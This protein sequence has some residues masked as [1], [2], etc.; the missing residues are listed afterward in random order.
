MPG[1]CDEVDLE[2]ASSEVLREALSDALNSVQRADYNERNK[3]HVKKVSWERAR[4][5]LLQ[6]TVHLLESDSNSATID[7]CAVGYLG[8]PPQAPSESPRRA[9]RQRPAAAPPEGPRRVGS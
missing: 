2:C 6:S 9:P 3:Q 1:V 8:S 4:E 5:L 7:L